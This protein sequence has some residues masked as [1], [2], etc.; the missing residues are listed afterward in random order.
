[1]ESNRSLL[2]NRNVDYWRF[3]AEEFRLMSYEFIDS[4]CKIILQEIAKG[5]DKLAEIQ[6]NQDVQ[7]YKSIK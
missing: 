1:M 6:E 2:T 5:Y 3:R 4:E 7:I